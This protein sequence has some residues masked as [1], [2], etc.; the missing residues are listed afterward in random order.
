MSKSKTNLIHA[1][2]LSNDKK[3]LGKVYFNDI[4]PTEE[5]IINTS[6]KKF[7]TDEPCIIY[8]TSIIKNFQLELYDYILTHKKNEN[9]EIAIQSL[10]E[11]ISA[12]LFHKAT[13]Y[14]K[15]GDGLIENNS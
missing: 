4:V 2:F 5:Y 11:T 15:I 9:I 10:P 3:V 13:A 1:I 8:R 6:I 14:I 12:I 7:N